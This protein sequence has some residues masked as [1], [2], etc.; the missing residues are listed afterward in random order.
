MSILARIA[1][2]LESEGIGVQGETIFVNQMSDDT[3]GVLLFEDPEGFMQHTNADDYYRGSFNI[4]VRFKSSVEGESLSNKI[5][6]L[7]RGQ[8][9]TFGEYHVLVA[10]PEMLPH[11]F[12][13]NEGGYVEWL[14]AF[15]ISFTVGE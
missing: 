13:R 14:L 15:E 2:Y 5:F 12:G 1:S 6:K 7:I 4:T 8:G 10:K 3:P 9:K 11:S